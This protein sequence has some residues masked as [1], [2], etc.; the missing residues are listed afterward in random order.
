[1]FWSVL[2]SDR[3]SF[4]GAAGRAEHQTLAQAPSHP[5]GNYFIREELGNAWPPAGCRG[6]GNVHVCGCIATKATS[7]NVGKSS[8]C[9]EKPSS[10][11]MRLF[12]HNCHRLSTQHCPHHRQCYRQ[13]YTISVHFCCLLACQRYVRVVEK[14]TACVFH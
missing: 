5:P 12:D 1:M 3:T 6:R 2:L 13:C 14:S 11:W 8:G 4:C 7:V 10:S 9:N